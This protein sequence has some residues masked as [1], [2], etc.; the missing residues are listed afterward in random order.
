MHISGTGSFQIRRNVTKKNWKKLLFCFRFSKFLPELSSAIEIS[1]P[2][3]LKRTRC[4]AAACAA[5]NRSEKNRWR[6]NASSSRPIGVFGGSWMPPTSLLKRRT[7][8]SKHI[9]SVTSGGSVHKTTSKQ[10][11]QKLCSLAWQPHHED[12]IT[13]QKHNTYTG[14]NI[15]NWLL[16]FFN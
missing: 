14:K 1:G 15:K 11:R 12:D 9:I 2:S 10:F 16:T 6:F 7:N 4:S 5:D 8:I 3:G 13:K